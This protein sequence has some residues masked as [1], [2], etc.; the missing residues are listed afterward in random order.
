MLTESSKET[1]FF[2]FPIAALHGNLPDVFERATSYA[3]LQ[4]ANNEV[5]KMYTE[6]QID[7]IADKQSQEYPN[8]SGELS[9]VMARILVATKLLRMTVGALTSCNR[10]RTRRMS[11]SISVSV[12][13]GNIG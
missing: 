13:K 2:R 4:C 1:R 11:R 12:L 8:F 7:A 3:L 9:D 10:D 6:E 5:P